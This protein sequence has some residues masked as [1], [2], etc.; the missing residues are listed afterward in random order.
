MGDRMTD[1][2][3]IWL[4]PFDAD[5]NYSEPIEGR[6]WCQDNVWG[7]GAVEFVRADVVENMVAKARAEMVKK[8]AKLY[9]EV[10]AQA[11][12]NTVVAGVHVVV[13]DD[14]FERLYDCKALDI[15]ALAQP[16]EPSK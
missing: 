14:K 11:G 6:M 10:C 3:R 16:K 4:E 5:G 1:H 2:E 7:D 9:C 8:C 12:C 15:L 13:G